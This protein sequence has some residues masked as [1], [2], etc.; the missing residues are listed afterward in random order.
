MPGP[1]SGMSIIANGDRI[2]IASN[3]SI[4]AAGDNPVVRGNTGDAAASG[5]IAV[6]PVDSEVTSGS[7]AGVRYSTV[8]TRR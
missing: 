5:T 1:V 8:G 2:V 4:V 3:G 7:S 6:D